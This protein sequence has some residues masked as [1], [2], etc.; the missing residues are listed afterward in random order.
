ME[1]M[2]DDTLRDQYYNLVVLEGL[3]I[4][5]HLLDMQRFLHHSR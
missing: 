3:V 1:G 4:L 5:Q 2:I